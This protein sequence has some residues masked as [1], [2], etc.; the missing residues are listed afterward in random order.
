MNY[1][2]YE[3]KKY[4]IN[5]AAVNVST[6]TTTNLIAATAT[7]RIL[8]LSFVAWAANSQTVKLQDT[9]AAVVLNTITAGAGG[10]W[11]PFQFRADGHFAPLAINVGLDIVT[12]AAVV[13][14][15]QLSH[16]LI[17]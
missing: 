12:G 14:S 4:K 11:L 2:N 1:I 6:A 15:G 17:D 13:L 8:I 7:K 5:H 16:A 3:G 10:L 9:A